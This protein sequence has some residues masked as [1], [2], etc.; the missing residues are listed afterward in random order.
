MIPLSLFLQ[1]MSHL[2]LRLHFGPET[3]RLSAARSITGILI[4]LVEPTVVMAHVAAR[5]H[6]VAL[7]L[8]QWVLDHILMAH[9]ITQGIMTINPALMRVIPVAARYKQNRQQPA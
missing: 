2:L 7:E 6:Q 9:A 1:E 8:T 3:S 5:V 4:S